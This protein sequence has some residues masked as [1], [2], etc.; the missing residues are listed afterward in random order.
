MHPNSAIPT[1]WILQNISSEYKV[2][3]VGD[4]QMDPYE[5]MEGSWYSYGSRDRTPGIEWLK[6]FK[7]KYKSRIGGCNIIHPRN[8]IEKDD[9]LCVPPYMTICL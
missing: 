5:L 9:I 7:E 3:I 1:E 2:I 8:L 4:A 6:R